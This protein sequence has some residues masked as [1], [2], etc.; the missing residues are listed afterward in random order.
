MDY[1]AQALRRLAREKRDLADRTAHHA[2]QRRIALADPSRALTLG[3]E[4]EAHAKKHLAM[5]RLRS[6]VSH[7][8][9]RSGDEF[10]K[11][12]YGCG[13]G[14][15]W[16]FSVSDAERAK[17][18]EPGVKHL[19][20]TKK[21]PKFDDKVSH[22]HFFRKEIGKVEGWHDQAGRKEARMQ[23]ALQ[24]SVQK[25]AR[26]ARAASRERHRYTQTLA[27]LR[28]PRPTSPDHTL[29]AERARAVSRGS[30]SRGKGL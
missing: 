20:R 26:D 28:F 18:D 1:Q 2:E 5:L 22:C 24:L 12:A 10:R 19:M 9:R 11:A 4:E 23:R 13:G 30:D 25:G 15:S 3:K 14:G 29:S 6:P 17:R 16:G 27:P 8:V 7:E 21:V